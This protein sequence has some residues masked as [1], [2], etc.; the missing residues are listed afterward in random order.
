[1]NA[2]TERR[3][4]SAVAFEREPVA[5]CSPLPKHEGPSME[6]P[7]ITFTWQINLG[8]VLVVIST[9]TAGTAAYVDLRRD[10]IDQKRTQAVHAARID[11]LAERL[12]TTD[13][14]NATFAARF[15]AIEELMREMRNDLRALAGRRPP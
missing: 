8:H 5:T 6:R 14:A 10:V 11:A 12:N 9:L 2:L 3:A 7:G 1:M 15:G 4:T 13:V